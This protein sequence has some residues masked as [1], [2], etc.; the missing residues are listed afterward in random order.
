MSKCRTEKITKMVV[1]YV[2]IMEMFKV[3]KPIENQGYS[4]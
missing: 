4:R 2:N 1:E 3:I